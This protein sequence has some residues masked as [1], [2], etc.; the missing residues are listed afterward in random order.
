MGIVVL[1][2]CSLFPSSVSR[3]LPISSL[4]SLASTSYYH[5]DGR[6]LRRAFCVE[7]DQDTLRRFPLRGYVKGV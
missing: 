1:A 6:Y 5:C 2:S 4:V 7:P 3:T